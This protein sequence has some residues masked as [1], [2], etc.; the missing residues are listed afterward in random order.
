MTQ[1]EQAKKQFE[2]VVKADLNRWWEESDL[3]AEDLAR[4]AVRAIEAWLD[5]EIVGFEPDEG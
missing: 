4:V 1:S 2:L 5:E 3:E